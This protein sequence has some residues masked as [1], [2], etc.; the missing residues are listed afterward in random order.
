MLHEV[1]LT[2]PYYCILHHRPFESVHEIRLRRAI[3]E[4]AELD[5]TDVS[6]LLVFKCDATKYRED[7]FRLVLPCQCIF[8]RT[9]SGCA[10]HI[11]NY[12]EEKSGQYERL[13]YNLDQLVVTGPQID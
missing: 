9:A 12:K 2:W 3:L 4:A 1:E 13:V 5:S 10:G 7:E 11:L 6:V 8:R